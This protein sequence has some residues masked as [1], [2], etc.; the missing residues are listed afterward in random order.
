MGSHVLTQTFG[1]VAALIEHD[2]KFLFVRENRTKHQTHD[3]GK[4]NHPAGWIEVGE[5]PIDGVKREVLEETGF[6]F[7]PTGVLGVYSLARDLRAVDGSIHHHIKLVFLGK[8]SAEPVSAIH[9]D[10]SEIRWFSP[11][12]IYAMDGNTLRDADIKTMIKNFLAD[13]RF[14][15]NTITHTVSK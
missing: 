8:T 9:D 10:V 4:W 7:T 2:G 15:L 12:K 14:D 3:H 1:V 6:D 11:E 5:N 13:K